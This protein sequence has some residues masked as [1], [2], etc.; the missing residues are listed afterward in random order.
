MDWERFYTELYS[1]P[2]LNEDEPRLLDYLPAVLAN[3]RAERAGL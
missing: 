1:R 3:L 2:E